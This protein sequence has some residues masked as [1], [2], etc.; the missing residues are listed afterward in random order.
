[1]DTDTTPTKSL[2]KQGVTL[3][4]RNRSG[5]PCRTTAHAPGGRPARRQRYRWQTTTTDTNDRY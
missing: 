2:V 1:M 4:G 3:T 5:P